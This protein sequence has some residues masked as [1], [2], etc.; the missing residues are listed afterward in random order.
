MYKSSYRTNPD[1]GNYI[2]EIA[3]GDYYEFF[4]EW[5]NTSF[6]KRDMHPELAEFLDLC[7]QDI[8]LRKGLEIHFCVESEN[9]DEGKEKMIRDSFDHYYDF[10]GRTEIKKIQRNFRNSLF[11]AAIGIGLVVLHA[12]LIREVPDQIWAEVVLEG[13]HIGGWVFLW[14]SLHNASFGSGERIH[15]KRE[16]SRL[17]KAS[18]LFQ[19]QNC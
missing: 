8:P 12:F 10:F 16:L 2:I 15:R 13:L 17:K 19:Y 18:L 1:T 11:L 3:L 7:S 9:R 14:E 6:K 4:H 5:D